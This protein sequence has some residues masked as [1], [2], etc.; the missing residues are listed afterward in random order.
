MSNNFFEN[1]SDGKRKLYIDLLEVT[2]SLSNLFAESSNPFLYYRAMENIFCKAFDA[3]NLSR[4][5]V[6]ADAG[7]DGI[8]IG[9]KTFLQNNGNTFQKVA[10]FNKDSNVLRNLKDM[11][12]V[13]KVASMR[14]ERIKS[15]MRICGLNDMMYHLVTRSDK[16][17]AIYE[18]HMDLI[19]I[20]SIRITKKNKNTIHFSDNIH[21]YS[22]SLS[23]S[24]LLKRF[25]T[26]D[27]RK[28]FGFYVDIL[29]DP[30]DFLLSI[31]SRKDDVDKIKLINTNDDIVDYIILPLYSPK[32]NEVEERSGLNQWNARGRKRN[33]NEVYIAI[34]SFIHKNKKNFFEYNTDDYKTESFNVKLPN[35]KIL[36]MKVAQ[37]GGKALMSNPNSALGEW[38]LREIL[39]LKPME[40]V[41]KEQ[42]DIIG[43]DSVKLSKSKAGIFYLDFLKS[44]SFE[45][46]EEKYREE[47]KQK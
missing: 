17:M 31:E 25:D 2:G 23:K 44:G 38:I 18:E 22:F 7:K 32:T 33:E 40:L 30:Y 35:G 34:P 14:N 41:T 12:L 37:Q 8:G 28:I 27:T 36:N 29:D 13:K 11:E 39:E 5:D 21:D 46:F 24:T 42:L 47:Y 20:D 3:E 45:E 16:Y 43:I 6:S 26:S 19:D 15:T 10:E 1:Q 9:L 4:S